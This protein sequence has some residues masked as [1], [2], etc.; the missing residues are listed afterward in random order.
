MGTGFGWDLSVGVLCD[1]AG[2]DR[3]EAAKQ[4][5]QGSGAQASLGILFDYEGD[6]VYQGT[7]QGYAS[8]SISYHSLPQC[9][10]NFGFVIDYGGKDQYGS[11]ARNTAYTVRGSQGGFIIDRP[12]E[13]ELVDSTKSLEATGSKA[14]TDAT[15]VSGSK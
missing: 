3:Y 11:G 8:R 12:K 9:G 1:F 14:P 10:G 6:D 4:H 15:S 5:T 13:E 7:G 2:N